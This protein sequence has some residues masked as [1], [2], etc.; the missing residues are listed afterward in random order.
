MFASDWKD[1]ENF[2]GEGY[3]EMGLNKVWI[4]VQQGWGAVA[5]ANDGKSTECMLGTRSD[6]FACGGES[7]SCS[8]KGKPSSHWGL[9]E[10]LG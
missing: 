6:L 5:E 3:F 4:S 8:W 7:V 10:S 9:S 2:H 1:L